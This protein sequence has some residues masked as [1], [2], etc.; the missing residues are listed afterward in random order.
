MRD[1]LGLKS[2]KR[3]SHQLIGSGSSVYSFALAV[4]KKA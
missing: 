1:R 3:F 2:P 4:Q